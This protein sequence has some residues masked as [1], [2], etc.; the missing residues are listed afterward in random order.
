MMLSG[1]IGR[2]DD[3]ADGAVSGGVLVS[4]L[5][6][7]PRGR[8]VS[9]GGGVGLFKRRR[10]LILSS[11]KSTDDISLSEEA[12]TCGTEH[13]L[14]GGSDDSQDLEEEKR[15]G[16]R[17]KGKMVNTPSHKHNENYL[18]IFSFTRLLVL[19]C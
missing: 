2:L 11:L 12:S 1:D 17:A 18:Q 14:L 4:T 8:A 10:M 19:K 16:K 5:V 6:T 7:D 13:C 3:T 15:R 9:D